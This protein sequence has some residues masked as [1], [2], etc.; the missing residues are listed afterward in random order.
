LIAWLLKRELIAKVTDEIKKAARDS[1]PLDE[2]KRS[3]QG[4]ALLEQMMEVERSDGVIFSRVL[5]LT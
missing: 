4:V 5:L 1:E 3:A 2:P